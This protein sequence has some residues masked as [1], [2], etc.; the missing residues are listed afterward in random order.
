MSSTCSP[1]F[2]R[3]QKKWRAS[4]PEVTQTVVPWGLH[5]PMCDNPALAAKHLTDWHR[6]QS[7]DRTRPG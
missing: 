2:C 5:L 6:H 3:F 4:L 1:G 7:E